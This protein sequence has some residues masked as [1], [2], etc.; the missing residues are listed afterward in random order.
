MFLLTACSLQ[1]YSL[2]FTICA[3]DG[4][5]TQL[6][7]FSTQGTCEHIK[8]MYLCI[9]VAL[10]YKARPPFTQL[11]W[12]T[13]KVGDQRLSPLPAVLQ[14]IFLSEQNTEHHLAVNIVATLLY[15]IIISLLSEHLV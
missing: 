4:L 2:L 7:V 1:F 14:S 13:D 11:F 15:L 10:C 6:P 3:P 9:S 5:H 12:Q 8:D